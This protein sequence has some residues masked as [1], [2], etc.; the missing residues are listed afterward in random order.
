MLPPLSTLTPT[1]QTMTNLI[2]RAIVKTAQ[3]VEEMS[4]YLVETE[5]SQDPDDCESMGICDE[6]L[7]IESFRLNVLALAIV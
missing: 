7:D 2:F 4:S 6:F 1:L 3:T 5:A